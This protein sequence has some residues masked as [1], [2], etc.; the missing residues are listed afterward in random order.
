MSLLFRSLSKNLLLCPAFPVYEVHLESLS[1][2]W[3]SISSFPTFHLFKN[4]TC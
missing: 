4:N 2:E 1:D 3:S